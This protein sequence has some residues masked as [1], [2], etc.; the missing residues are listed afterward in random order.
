M[1]D[2]RSKQGRG[3]GLALTTSDERV[4][5]SYFSAKG[6]GLPFLDGNKEKFKDN[7]VKM[8]IL[9]TF[10]ATKAQNVLYAVFP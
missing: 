5:V 4:G 2:H 8:A 7:S 9:T 1:V 3:V 6:W 10:S